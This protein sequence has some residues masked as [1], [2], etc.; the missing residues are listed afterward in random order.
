MDYLSLCLIAKDEDEY[1]QEWIDYHILI[2]VDRFYIYDNESKNPIRELLK[3]YIHLGWAIVHEIQ[4]TAVQI[5]AYQHCIE[6]YG[7]NTQWM[8]FIDA[9]EFIVLNDGIDL[10]NFLSG[11]EKYGGLALSSVFFGPGHHVRHPVGGQI[12]NY[13]MR[14][15]L[16]VEDNQFVKC[17]VQPDKVTFANSPHTYYFQYP[18]FCVNSQGFRVDEQKFPVCFETIQLNHYFTR[19]AEHI[20]KKLNRLG[21]AG[22][23]LKVSNFNRITQ[24]KQIEDQQ[25]FR[26][27]ENILNEKQLENKFEQFNQNE[28]GFIDYLH[29]AARKNLPKGKIKTVGNSLINAENYFYEYVKLL[30]DIRNNI[31]LGNLQEARQQILFYLKTYPDFTNNPGIY[32]GYA[33]ISIL[34]NNFN[35]AK[36]ALELSFKKFGRVFENLRVLADFYVATRQFDLAEAVYVEMQQI[37]NNFDLL[38]RLLYVLLREMKYTEADEIVNLLLSQFTDPREYRIE[39]YVNIISEYLSILEKQKRYAEIKKIKKILQ[40]E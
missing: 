5:N 7:K 34:Q 20:N 15:P 2:G 10:K 12:I 40:I 32:T 6:N 18:Y 24:P 39:P 3:D 11:V 8:G 13:Q 21:G 38:F 14:P 25:I 26:F 27:L 19:S 30:R 22:R 35:E 33:T 9:D 23:K 31:Q 28:T 29:Q 36:D 16:T 17:I 1:L 37:G 4:G